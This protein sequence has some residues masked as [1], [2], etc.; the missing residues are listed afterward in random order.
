M[1]YDDRHVAADPWGVS[2]MGNTSHHRV[3]IVGGG[4]AGVAVAARLVANG[5]SDVAIIEPSTTHYYQPL[6]TLVGGGQAKASSTERDRVLGDAQ[7]RDVDRTAASAFDP[8]NNTVTCTDGATYD[9]DVLVVCPGIQLDWN[10]TE[11]L[12]RHPRPRRRVVELPVRPRAAHLGL[13][14]QPA[15]G[16]RG[17]HDAVRARSS[18]PERRRRSPTWPRTTGESRAC[19]RTSTCTWSCPA[20]RLFGIPAIADSLDKVIADYGITCTPTPR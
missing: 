7:G 8:D 12:E 5:V 15:F 19:S 18:A 13:H 17:V 10:R 2:D 20:P 14:P 4:T 9:Y 6:W 1:A 16:H 3:V 11:G